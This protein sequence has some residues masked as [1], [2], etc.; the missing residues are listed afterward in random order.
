MLLY[1]AIIVNKENNFVKYVDS[2]GIMLLFEIAGKKLWYH[3]TPEKNKFSDGFI[4]KTMNVPYITDLKLYKQLQSKLAELGNDDPDYFEVLD[5]LSSLRTYKQIP[6]ATYF[7]DNRMVAKTYADERRAF[8][9]QSAESGIF[10]AELDLGKTLVIDAGGK[11]FS[12]IPKSEVL[13]HFEPDQIDT[14]ISDAK[15]QNRVR[16]DDILALAWDAGYDSVLFNRVIDTYQG[17]GTVSNV[18]AVFD[19]DRIQVV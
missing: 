16:S 2:E 9:Y 14:F 5:R 10:A 13:K 19:V 4:Q 8:D 6:R 7:T 1:T 18:V 11:K 3:G 12:E 15:K 17:S